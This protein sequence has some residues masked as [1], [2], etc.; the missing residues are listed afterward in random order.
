MIEKE[1]VPIQPLGLLN[2]EQLSEVYNKSHGML[3]ASA[4]E[5]LSFVALEGIAYGLSIIATNVPGVREILKDTGILIPTRI[6]GIIDVE[7]YAEAVVNVMS[8]AALQHKLTIKSHQRA[9]KYTLEKMIEKTVQV[10]R[11]LI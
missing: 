11:K 3:I 6:D 5:C 9:K 10:Y 8:D 2:K 7:K 4:C 1:Q